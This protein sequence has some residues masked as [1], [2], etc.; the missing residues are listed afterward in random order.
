MHLAIPLEPIL[1]VVGIGIGGVAV[2][3]L[4]GIPSTLINR[5]I[6]VAGSEVLVRIVGSGRR[7]ELLG[8]D[9]RAIPGIEHI[10]AVLAYLGQTVAVI[11]ET[12]A[13]QVDATAVFATE[14]LRTLDVGN[15]LEES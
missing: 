15:L 3:I 5:E 6:L 2:D 12:P 9:R 11:E 1:A 13:D 14:L 4:V 10:A 8:G 7:R